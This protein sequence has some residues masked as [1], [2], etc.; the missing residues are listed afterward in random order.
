MSERES[1]LTPEQRALL[2][3]RRMRARLEAQEAA[4]REPIAVVGLACRFP[5]GADDPEA[6]W[7]LLVEGREGI[8]EVPADRWPVDQYFDPDPDAP[9][10][11]YTRCGGFLSR[12]DGFEPE[13]FGLS[14]RE[15]VSLDPQHR[16]LLEV[17]WEAL[18]SAG[19]APTGLAG[20][21]TGVYVGI[22][23]TEYSRLV[24]AEE[25]SRLEAHAGTGN[26]LSIAANRISYLLGLEGPSLAV[27]T[28]CSSSLVAVHLAC[29]ALRGNEIDLALVGG[30]SLMLAPDGSVIFCRSRMLSP[31][32]RSKTFDAAADGYGRGEGCGV[33]VLT[34][35]SEAVRRGLR[36]RAL[37]RASGVNQD[38][39]STG[40]TAPNEAAQQRLIEQVVAAAGIAPA[41]VALL[42]AHGTGTA[43]GDP[44]EVQA[45]AAALGPGRRR[46]RPLLLGSVKANLGHLEA[47]AGVAGLIKLVLAVEQGELPPQLHFATP[48]PHVPWDQLPVEV[49]TR[50][51]PWPEGYER[52]RGGVSSFG[53]GGTNAHVLVE[54]APP[55][56][57]PPEP[58]PRP[59][60]LLTLAARTETALA[61]QAERWAAHLEAHPELELADVAFTAA[62][63]R[64]PLG[65][66]RA[67][68]AGDLR[69]AAA[70]L[71]SGAGHSGFATGG[72][73]SG[74]A[75]LFSGQGTQ[76]AGTGAELYATEPR[77]RDALDE[78]AGWLLEEGGWDLRDALFRDDGRL[79]ATEVAQPCLFAVGYGL[80][81]LYRALGLPVAAVLGHSIGEYV[82]ACAA[83]M[84]PWREGL[85]LVVLRG[86]L[87]QA[88][89]PGRMVA[90][91]VSEG[92]AR[93]A[94]AGLEAAAVAAVNGER[95]VVISGE[96]AAVGEALRRLGGVRTK[97]LGVD[98]AFHSPLMCSAA[99]ELQRAWEAVGPLARPEV[100]VVW[101]RTGRPLGAGEELSPTYW[102]RQLLEPV[103]FA[104]SVR[105][106]LDRGVTAFLELGLT[107]A[108][109]PAVSAAGEGL[110]TAASLRKGKGDWE[111]VLDG[112]GRLWVSGVELDLGAL[113][114]PWPRRRVELPAYP[115]ERRSF[116][117]PSGNGS[118]R[119]VSRTSSAASTAQCFRSVAEAAARQ[120]RFLPIDLD[121]ARY[122][123]QHECL[124]RLAT[125]VMAEAL[126]GLGL[127]GE[128]GES[129]T[130]AEALARSGVLPTYRHLLGRWLDKLAACG[131][132][133]RE[134]ADR[135]R[136]PAPLEP[137]EL[138]ALWR[139]IETLAPELEVLLDYFRRCQRLL[140]PVLRGRESALETLFPGGSFAVAES[141]YRDWAVARYFNGVM[142]SA[143]SALALAR[144]GEAPLAVLEIGAGTGGT[145]QAVIAALPPAGTRY[146]YTD[147]SPHFFGRAREK[148]AAFPFVSFAVF[149]VE[150]EPEPQ[151]L[152]PASFDLIVAANVLHATRDLAQT[153]ARVAGLL[154]PGGVLLLYETVEHPPWFDVTTGL[155]E[156]WQVFDDDLRRDH[157]LLDRDAWL[158]A[159][160]AVGLEAAAA[161][162]EPGSPAT[163]FG[164]TV[165][166]A[167]APGERSG[168][169]AGLP[170]EA[171]VQIAAPVPAP[172]G[173]SP[174]ERRAA[175]AAAAP[176]RRLEL[177]LDFVRGEVAAVLAL[178]PGRRLSAQ[179]RLMELGLD[180]LMAV[181]LRNRL[182]RG[183]AL[184][185][186]LPVTLVF[187]HPT[188]E[189]VALHL[190]RDLLG[191]EVARGAAPPR[192][193][194]PATPVDPGTEALAATRLA[195]L[196]DQEVAALLAERL[197]ASP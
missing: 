152:A 196:S 97:D 140:L 64:A 15:A 192:P 108:L 104:E 50:R 46:D 79:A 173:P 83:G 93:A 135:F 58:P 91:E 176:L 179:D 139:E 138:E 11:T 90:V 66:R 30:V 166:F 62:V 8:V 156:G 85:R 38:G 52:R 2:A 44:I 37:L 143:T 12:V 119:A 168:D 34:R 96:P 24:G 133:E 162:P 113:D 110:V 116:W 39:R 190:G 33:L 6:F 131:R 20:S 180:S 153:L 21:R 144:S 100:E 121:A 65:Q 99:A 148:L 112:L 47:A 137:R 169:A 74:V 175:L 27:D 106:L 195:G 167:H 17:A 132:L 55:V 111:S 42:E 126:K 94:L 53:F 19:L 115:W 128:A 189:A 178:E 68:V 72:T 9:G 51:R 147:V 40:L 183:L 4:A 60:H 75:V 194:A 28:A 159:L 134:G 109:L 76:R 86:R 127:F 92:E 120:S 22:A 18:E 155:I 160:A 158:S 98:R 32:G 145:S 122:P 165:L 141:L 129:V 130:L 102:S 89:A 101:N 10:R 181:D 118:G 124:D 36:T 149:D 77:F 71:R 193:A 117:W 105:H 125:E 150:A 69:G 80:W 142:G 177:L 151:G 48:N 57:E 170:S 26:A 23:S 197:A 164:Q 184:D 5:G 191:L 95:S 54:E 56:V 188:V 107:P 7:R 157:P 67:V 61:R 146:L 49:I 84:L 171:V 13:M 185:A 161:L 136:A 63:G 29:Q 123:S 16:L 172:A 59:R 88:T 14:P 73:G 25:P 174:D 45:A 78:A 1:E 186:S 43:L 31:D 154:A 87:M 35:A 3:L 163:I 81:Q 114:A 103:R 182:A 82:A 41:E 187:D 70:A